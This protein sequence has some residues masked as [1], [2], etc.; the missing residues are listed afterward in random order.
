MS[1]FKIKTNALIKH[2]GVKKE[3][4]KPDGPIIAEIKIFAKGLDKSIL[5]YFD[6]ALKDFLWRGNEGALIVRNIFLNDVGYTSVIEDA[7]IKIGQLEFNGGD[8]CKFI[9]TPADGGV[10]DLTFNVILRPTEY[11]LAALSALV[12]DDVEVAIESQPDLFS[13]R[14][15]INANSSIDMK[16]GEI[17]GEVHIGAGARIKLKEISKKLK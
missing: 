11:E 3:G 13:P 12:L 9:I 17:T 6:D 1:T 4:G 14:P 16:T 10:I 7:K 15:P 5:D 8:A 2:L